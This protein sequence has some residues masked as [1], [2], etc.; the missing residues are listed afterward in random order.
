MN[1]QAWSKYSGG[2]LCQKILTLM[3]CERP[4]GGPQSRIHANFLPFSCN[5]IANI[6]LFFFHLKTLKFSENTSFMTSHTVPNNFAQPRT[7]LA[8]MHVFVTY[9][10][11]K[12]CVFTNSS[13]K[14]GLSHNHA[15]PYFLWNNFVSNWEGGNPPTSLPM[16]SQMCV[17]ALY[18]MEN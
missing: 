12:K 14:K 16:Q 1:R 6:K 11:T 10:S 5:H 2:L 18:V 3:P 15:D 13:R 17:T 7:F 4:P 9:A 8:R